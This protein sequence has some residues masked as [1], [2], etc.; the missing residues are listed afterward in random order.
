M[1]LLVLFLACI[2]SVSGIKRWSSMKTVCKSGDACF[3]PDN[4]HW[5]LD[6][7]PPNL[8]SLT[9]RGK[10]QWDTETAGLQLTAGHV[11]VEGNG[12]LEI[13]TTL[14]PMTKQ[15]TIYISAE[16]AAEH[17]SFGQRFLAA[18]DHAEILMHGRKLITWTLLAQDLGAGSSTLMLRDDPVE[19]SWQVGDTIGIATTSRGQSR[20]YKIVSMGPGKQIEIDP[21][22]SAD[23]LGG[24]RQIRYNGWSKVFDQRFELAAEVVNLQRSIAITGPANWDTSDWKGLH[25]LVTG[26]G[27]IDARYILVENCGQP[28]HI[29][30]YCLHLH[31]MHQCPRC[32][33]LGNAVVNSTQVGITVHGTHGAQVS[34]NVL[35]NTMSA[36]VYVEDGNEMN[37][38]IEENVIICMHPVPALNPLPCNKGPEGIC[39]EARQGCTYDLFNSGG[40]LAGVYVVGMTNN[41]LRN[42]VVNM[43]NCFWFKGVADPVGRGHAAGKVCPVH[44]PFGQIKG[45]VCHDNRRFGIY[46]DFQRPRMLPRDENGFVADIENPTS[47]CFN[48]VDADGKDT[49]LVPANVVEDE[50]D[51]HNEFVGQY[52]LTDVR[53]SRYVGINN[54]HCMYWKSSKNFADGSLYHITDSICINAPIVGDLFS[55][56]AGQ[57]FGPAGG[58]TFGLKNV[59]FVGSP[60]G[61]AA[62]AAGQHCMDGGAGGPCN[63]QYLLENVDFSGVSATGKL[64]QHGVNSKPEGKVW[65]VF[66]ARDGSLGGFKSVLSQHLDG[67][68]NEGCVQLGPEWDSGL[69]CN[70]AV[71]RLN[72]WTAAEIEGGVKLS[73]P[74]FAVAANNEFPSFGGNAGIL[75]YAAG[76]NGYGALCRPGNVYELEG[77]WRDSPVIDVAFSDAALESIFGAEEVTLKTASGSCA[78]RSEAQRFIGRLGPVPTAPQSECGALLFNSQP[79]SETLSISNIALGRPTAASS[80][81]QSIYESAKAVDGSVDTRW[82]SSFQ[83]NQWISV[84]LGVV[85]ELF[86]VTVQWETAYARDYLVQSALDEPSWH[87]AATVTINEPG[88]VQTLFPEHFARY[89]RILCQTRATP[90]GCSILELQVF[91][92]FAGL[93]HPVDGGTSRACRGSSRSDNSPS[94]YTVLQQNTLKGCKKECEMT[95]SCVGVE[96]SGGRCEIWTRLG[97]IESAVVL[98]G[99]TC[100]HFLRPT[101]SC[102]ML[103]EGVDGGEERACRGSTADD[104][105]EEYFQGKEAQTLE[106]CEAYC[107]AEAACVGISYSKCR[108][109]IWVRPQGIQATTA[110]C[111]SV[112]KRMVRWGLGC[113]I[114]TLFLDE[115]QPLQHDEAKSSSFL[116]TDRTTLILVGVAVVL[117][118]VLI[119]G[120]FLKRMSW[121]SLPP[122]SVSR[123]DLVP[124]RSASRQ[125]LEA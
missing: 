61:G 68:K 46:L 25:T 125:D 39:P 114:Q 14:K 111:G 80:S 3:V 122:R 118:L 45:N 54:Q 106:S 63:V 94:H 10:L 43:E 81:E 76:Y 84:D 33:L 26:T 1:A 78:V 16:S 60:G 7:S 123:Q 2:P 15:A 105:S 70:F 8:S 100:L 66:L 42:R 95:P 44:L 17:T 9:I 37:N 36:G 52:T 75:S 57:F 56:P 117:P 88:E 110:Q 119:L 112:C 35:W 97:G 22:A 109:E 73:G 21:P 28:P 96:Y 41:F 6:W 72:V 38:S 29:G 102:L 34:K 13:G 40:R 116:R 48:E 49:G 71:R 12:S 59:T 69:G 115:V 11:L 64:I 30:R 83:D 53:Y 55:I 32:V 50:L 124:E 90:W 101:S 18:K 47:N 62:L 85:Y 107:E 104:N 120:C 92:A 108:C 51:W 87:T 103:F 20:P 5:L 77:V 65:P 4:E 79:N 23:Y 89:V 74:G 82:S 91:P 113:P 99:F 98:Q 27:F 19:M 121:P 93:F 31:L 86:A 58:F 24:W 67:F